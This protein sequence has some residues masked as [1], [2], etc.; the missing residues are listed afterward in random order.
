MSSTYA[1]H[2]GTDLAS[3][4][5]SG[6]SSASGA[7]PGAAC[8]SSAGTATTTPTE[9]LRPGNDVNVD[10]E[11][12]KDRADACGQAI[13][14]HVISRGSC[15]A[16]KRPSSG[17]GHGHDHDHD[18]SDF[19]HS[20]GS[21]SRHHS[22]RTASERKLMQCLKE[23]IKALEYWTAESTE[24]A[25]TF[26]FEGRPR[27]GHLLRYA[28]HS[29]AEISGIL[30]DI[31]TGLRTPSAGSALIKSAMSRMNTG[32]IQGRRMYDIVNSNYMPWVVGREAA[33]RALA[34]RLKE[35]EATLQEMGI[36]I[37]TVVA[38]TRT[39]TA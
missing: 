26:R 15:A 3:A 34:S 37:G 19:T 13:L 24:V 10:V 6:I 11:S 27:Y 20:R 39:S 1:S 25:D 9:S 4:S 33:I 18:Q 12:L 32:M 8:S 29:E 5:T 17:H 36:T 16:Q 14:D 22:H 38:G 31:E 35:A 21:R 30:D 7:A 2:L 28:E 23:G